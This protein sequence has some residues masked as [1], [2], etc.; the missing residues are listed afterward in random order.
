M[1]KLAYDPHSM[2]TLASEP[3]NALNASVEA[4]N[5]EIQTLQS[6]D[7]LLSLVQHAPEHVLL[8]NAQRQIVYAND[9][10]LAMANTLGL[11]GTYGQPLGG[12]LGCLHAHDTEASCGTR[13]VCKDCGALNA[14]K[15]SLNGAVAMQ[16][17]TILLKADKDPLHLV[18]MT[19]P[20]HLADSDYILTVF[21]DD[22]KIIKYPHTLAE[23]AFAAQKLAA[24]I[25]TA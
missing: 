19:I 9:A 16:R 10:Y 21:V 11:N 18:T 22:N 4:L 24:R 12:Y 6:N 7:I 2:T 17:C 13:P 15:K 8:L 23:H 5:A 1:K 25:Q 14:V 3:P 20:I